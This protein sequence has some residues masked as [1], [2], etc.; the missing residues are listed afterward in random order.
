MPTTVGLFFERMAYADLLW[1]QCD[2]PYGRHRDIQL[3]PCSPQADRALVIGV[4]YQA[5]ADPRLGWQDRLASKVRRDR[6]ARKLA[7]AWMGL[8]LDRDRTTALFYE[9]QP[10]IHDADYEAAGRHAARVY[11]TDER[12]PHPIPLPSTWL[13]AEDVHVL[14]TVEPPRKPVPLAV[15]T[16]GARVVPGH[17][18]RLD[19]LRRLRAAGVEFE[20]FGRG[21]PGDLA[22][23]GPVLSKSAALRPARFVLSLENHARGDCYVTEK[24]W[25][26]LLCWSLPLYYGSRAADRVIPSESFVRLPDLGAGGVDVV[27]EALAHPAWWH[28]RLDAIAEA[29][30]RILGELRMVEW[31]R[32]CVVG[33]EPTFP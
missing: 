18:A 27:L 13:L 24:M 22:G 26:P 19:F 7:V 28:E 10:L 30:R 33:S 3:V 20:L 25:D 11:G 9:P 31:I 1:S 14:R 16:S 29:R 8:D 2:E 32:R 6:R 23:R 12:A 5:G 17:Q 15:V 4:P 21:L